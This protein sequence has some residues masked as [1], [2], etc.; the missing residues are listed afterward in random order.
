[1]KKI[2]SLLVV[3]VLM[4]GMMSMSVSADRGLKYTAQYGSATIDGVYDDA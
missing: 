2:L 4:L 1:M 3:A